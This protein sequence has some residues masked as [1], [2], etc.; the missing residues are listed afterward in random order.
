VPPVAVRDEEYPYARL[1]DEARDGRTVHA[2]DPIPWVPYLAA[3]WNPRPWTSPRADENHRRFF[4]FPTQAEWTAELRAIRDDFDKYPGLGLPLP[5]NKRQKILT[6]YAWNEFGEGGILAP[7]RGD[8]Y[9]RLEAL[10]DVF[11]RP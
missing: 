8:G 3:G 7:T 5:Q 9:R 4:R 11:S 1:A 10:R 6:I 2:G